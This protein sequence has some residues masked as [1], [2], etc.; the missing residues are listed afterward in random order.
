MNYNDAIDYIHNSL[1]FGIK[2]GLSNMNALMELLGNPHK[3]IKCVHVAGTNGKGSVV[4]FLSEILIKAG[5]TVGTFTSPYIERFSERIRVN[6]EEI[7]SEEIAELVEKIKEKADYIAHTKQGNLTEFEIVT[8]IAF[9]Y[10]SQKKCDIVIL[11]SGLGGRSDSTNIIDTPLLS[12]ITTI[13]YDHTEILGNT[14]TE[15]A[16]EKAGIIKK[17][18]DVLIYPQPD[19]VK[20]VIYDV[21]EN[22]DAEITQADF[23]EIRSMKNDIKGSEFSFG[24]YDD[25]KIRLL[26][27]YQVKNAVMAILAC[28]ILNK[29]GF[30]ISKDNIKEGLF[31][32]KWPGRFEILCEEPLFIIDGAH[33]PEG[34]ESL[35]ENIRQYFPDKKIIFILGVMKDKDYKKIVE[36]VAPL[37]KMF[38]TV[39]PSNKRALSA[40]ELGEITDNYCNNTIIGDT[41]NMAV[42]GAINFAQSDDVIIAFGSLYYIG[43]IRKI[44]ANNNCCG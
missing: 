44:M 31:G 5:Y 25:L 38:V 16:Y 1:K 23:N 15:I 22:I 37:A 6:G 4:A 26:G 19:E 30:E 34:A 36:T 14:L 7:S 33:N 29:K 21:A 3:D 24:D 13:S 9:M 35:A 17:G 32:T 39:T 43:E 42:L 12:I 41:I 27:N 28:E 11:E 10:F 2:L 20:K 8:A 18:S 40:E